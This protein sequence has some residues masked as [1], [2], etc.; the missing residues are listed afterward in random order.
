VRYSADGG[1]G[2]RTADKLD[3]LVQVLAELGADQGPAR[4]TS[5][6]IPERLHRAVALLA[7][8]VGRRRRTA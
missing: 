5:V 1:G 6:R 3:E 7:D 4:A 2:D 8:G